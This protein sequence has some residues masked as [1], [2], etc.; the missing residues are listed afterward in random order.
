LIPS[1]GEGEVLVADAER[2]GDIEVR[3]TCS[4]MRPVA[5]EIC[6]MNLKLILCSRLEKIGEKI[7]S[8]LSQPVCLHSVNDGLNHHDLKIS[9]KNALYMRR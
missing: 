6:M 4:E 8:L 1:A 2:P 9:G 3:R 5:A 7:S